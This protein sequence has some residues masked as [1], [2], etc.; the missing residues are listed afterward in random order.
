MEYRLHLTVSDLPLHA[1]GATQG[2]LDSLC[3]ER[4]ASAPALV[5]NGDDLEVAIGFDAESEAQAVRRGVEALAAALDAN[6]L[7]TRYPSKVAVQP[8]DRGQLELA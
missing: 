5:W 8:L 7:G 2:L 3:A 4:G 6:G 1:E